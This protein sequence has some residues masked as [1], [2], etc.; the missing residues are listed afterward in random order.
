[1]DVDL[2]SLPP[3]P[4]SQTL[5]KDEELEFNGTPARWTHLRTLLSKEEIIE[6][7]KNALI[8]RGWKFEG[9]RSEFLVF[10]KPNKIM[11]IR[12]IKKDLSNYNEVYLITSN[13]N[14]AVC[15]KLKEYFFKEKLAPDFSGT[16]PFGIP[17]YPKSKR[18]MSIVTS[19][20]GNVFVY[21]AEG[22]I[23]EIADFYRRNLKR[24]GWSESKVFTTK[25]AKNF[26]SKLKEKL[27]TLCFEKGK[28]TIVINIFL[29]QKNFLKCEACKLKL[30]PLIV[31]TQN[32]N[33]Y[34][35]RDILKEE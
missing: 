17:R 12:I 34:I 19:F 31:I 16:D 6:F 15:G 3:L 26:F 8:E 24:M 14:L 18:R 5:W 27:A 25:T 7:Y 28:D 22:T 35:E 23:S 11:Y 13:N 4:K 32:I 1:M 2:W 20:E 21:E 33:K 10:R 29:P 30:R 9:I